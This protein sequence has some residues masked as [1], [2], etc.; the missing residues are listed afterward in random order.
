MFLYTFVMEVGIHQ[1][2]SR[3]SRQ[4]CTEPAD[5][6]SVF[7]KNFGDFHVEHPI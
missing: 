5:F 7:T 1:N 6:T 3:I 4:L 2:K